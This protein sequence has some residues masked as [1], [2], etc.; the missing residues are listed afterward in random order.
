MG[1]NKRL[2]GKGIDRIEF[3]PYSYDPDIPNLSPDQLKRM[4]KAAKPRLGK[5]IGKVIICSTKG[6]IKKGPA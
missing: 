5:Y 1:L 3:Y 6:D 2:K 4:W